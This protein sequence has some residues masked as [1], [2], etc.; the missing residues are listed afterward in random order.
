MNNFIF[1]KRAKD[2]EKK[3]LD[4]LSTTLGTIFASQIPGIVAEMRIKK[5]LGRPTTDP[6][7]M[8]LID[9][10]RD[11]I[12]KDK[13]IGALALARVTQPASY[14]AK[15]GD[16]KFIKHITESS[17]RDPAILAHE[18]GH[19]QNKWLNEELKAKRQNK[20]IPI[21]SKLYGAG[22]FAPGL[23]A[24]GSML[25]DNENI[26]LIANSLGSA[27]TAPMLWEELTASHKGSKALQEAAKIKNIKLTAL[28]KLRP[29]MG[30]PTYM[31]AA[32]FPLAMHF[33][34]KWG[35]GF[36]DNA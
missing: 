9:G 28:Q 5:L 19:T 2:T 27:T 13:D 23:I 33:G 16:G 35:I 8:A 18:Y 12:A 31:A 1:I 4:G 26:S 10:L 36:K 25:T 29:Y 34:R 20:K 15:I 6:T 3:T 22:K 17:Y 7:N 24:T 11:I 32:A 30:I 21:G 14:V